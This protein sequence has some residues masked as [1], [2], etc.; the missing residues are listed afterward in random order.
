[1]A[2][3]HGWRFWGLIAAGAA[4]VLVV[5]ALYVWRDD[6]IKALLDPKV[7]FGKD[8]PPPA[9]DYAMRGAWALIPDPNA[10]PAGGR[11][12]LHS[13][14]LLSGLLH[15]LQRP[16]ALERADH[17]TTAPAWCAVAR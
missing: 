5:A 9:A 10:T 16:A 14:N 13:P 6:V 7:P 11:R 8:H 4:L 15:L 2:E 17:T 12:V 1:M 3:R